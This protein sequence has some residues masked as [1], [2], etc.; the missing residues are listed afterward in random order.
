MKYVL[1]ICNEM[2]LINNSCIVKRD[3]VDYMYVDSGELVD[4][5]MGKYSSII[6][7]SI[8]LVKRR[9]DIK[10]CRCTYKAL[11]IIFYYLAFLEIMPYSQSKIF[12][13]NSKLTL[14]S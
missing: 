4:I 13:N 6:I 7:V 14:L 1:G 10:F 8:F 9:N 12:K 2:T 5:M 3:K 11:A